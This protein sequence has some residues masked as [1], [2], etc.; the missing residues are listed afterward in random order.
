[1]IPKSGYRFSDKTVLQVK[2]MISKV[3]TGSRIRSC[4]IK[5]MSDE[6][7]SARLIGF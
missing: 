4:S 5:A 1:M 2:G 3:A 6:A 7:D